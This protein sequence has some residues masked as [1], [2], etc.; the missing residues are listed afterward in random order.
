MIPPSGPCNKKTIVDRYNK[1]L[2]CPKGVSYRKDILI[3]PY[4]KCEAFWSYRCSKCFCN[5]STILCRAPFFRRIKRWNI[6]GQ[7]CRPEFE[8]TRSS[9]PGAPRPQ[10]CG[11]S[12]CSW[13]N[14][15]GIWELN[16]SIP[17]P[18]CIRWP[19]SR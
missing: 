8:C 16:S 17:P 12:A 4:P 5:G 11:L 6:V 3:K 7:C 14:P 9:E 10:N 18:Q 15:E 13:Q 1:L 2:L 19:C